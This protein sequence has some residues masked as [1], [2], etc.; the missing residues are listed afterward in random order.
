[1]GYSKL[2]ESSPKLTCII[3]ENDKII[4]TS[5]KRG[6]QPIIDFYNEAKSYSNITIVDRII[7]KGAMMLALLVN[8]QLIYTPVISQDALEL[9]NHHGLKCNYSEVVPFIKNRNQTGRCPI[10]SSVLEIHDIQK[11]YQIILETLEN[12]RK[13]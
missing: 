12:L 6:V 13:A 8:A 1:M 3:L 4:F 7:G 5:T 2:L 9:A 10:E 11:G